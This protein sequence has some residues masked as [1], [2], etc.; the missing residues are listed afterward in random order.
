MMRQ[1]YNGKILLPGGIWIEG[2]SVVVDNGTIAEVCNHSR[3][4]DGVDTRIDAKGGYVLP[5]GIDMHVHGGGGHDF[6]EATRE[7]FETVVGVHRRHGTTSMFPTIASATR[8]E[9]R[10]AAEVCT[11]LMDEPDSGVLGLHLEGPYFQPCMVGG[12]MPENI[13]MPSPEEYVALVDEFPCIRRWDSAPELPGACDFARFITGKGIVAGLGHTIAG[14]SAVEAA[15]ASGY[16]LATHFYNAMTTSHKEGIYKHEGTVES[17]FINDGINV[18]VI[19]DG[20][21]VPP[22]ILKLIHKIKG[23]EKMCLVTDALSITESPDGSSYDPRVMIENGVCKLKDGSAIAGSCA[24]MDRLI[25][26]AATVAGIPLADVARMISETPARIM[27]VYDRKGS[28]CRG[29]DADIIVMDKELNL[30]HVMAMGRM[31]RIDEIMMC[32]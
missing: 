12:Q 16:T 7:A 1:I 31:V 19:A 13:R 9:I 17:V 29:K 32:L 28:L 2:G 3:L 14:H 21:H 30:T 18:E 10:R 24:T 15:Y 27:G 20:I 25:R 26:T 8:E 4:F 6:V 11:R 23:Y 5:G 22:V